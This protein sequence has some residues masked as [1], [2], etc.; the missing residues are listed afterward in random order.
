M[1]FSDKK[2][3]AQGF[4]LIEVSIALIIVGILIA[5]ALQV[6]NIYK[7]QRETALLDSRLEV[8]KSSLSRYVYR[9]GRYPLPAPR[10]SSLGSATIGREIAPAAA[11]PCPLPTAPTG[12][13]C[14]TN[15][16]T[17]N[18]DLTAGTDDVLIGDIPFATLGI[19]YDN[20]VD[21]WGNKLIYAISENLTQV[22]T[23]T[24]GYHES[25]GAIEVLSSAGTTVFTGGAPKAHYV[26]V[27][28]GPN[29]VGSFGLGGTITQQCTGVGADLTNCDTDGRFNSNIDFTSPPTSFSYGK[30]LLNFAAGAN[31]FD[32]KLAYANSSSF[33]IW[34][35]VAA[36]TVGQV[37][38]ANTNTQ[39][40]KIGPFS[41]IAAASCGTAPCT[42]LPYTKVDVEGSARATEI[43]ANRWC[44]DRPGSTTCSSLI[45]TSPL[46]ANTLSPVTLG[47]VPTTPSATSSIGSWY[48]SQGG[49]I[50]CPTDMALAGFYQSEELCSSSA[51]FSN[52]VNMG[53]TAGYYPIGLNSDG[54]Y[55]CND[56]VPCY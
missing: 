45:T 1:K 44:A 18:A 38:I 14:R 54:T 15:I 51:R 28:A 34:S 3:S 24:T 49:G 52:T 43:H 33:G 53:C 36:T 16:N 39:N 2:S 29:R 48:R 25:W 7:Q 46:P 9:Y 55:C 17:V 26:I 4:S 31:Y 6:Y 13:V 32:D 35:R 10:S 23:A 37:S 12:S 40:V 8:V 20:I 22:G 42:K 50:L 19:R 56:G 21:P 11:V 47:G 27:S 5:A 41:N 30:T